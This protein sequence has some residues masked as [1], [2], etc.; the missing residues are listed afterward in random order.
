MPTEQKSDQDWSC[1][2]EQSPFAGEDISVALFRRCDMQMNM[3]YKYICL[4]P[5]FSALANVN[6]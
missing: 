3:S 2:E 4:N 5:F 1:K 6:L